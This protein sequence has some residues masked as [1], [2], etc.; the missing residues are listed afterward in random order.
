MIC[1]IWNIQSLFVEKII[2]EVN[3]IKGD[4][5]CLTETKKKWNCNTRPVYASLFRN[6]EFEKSK[7]KHCRT[8]TE[9]L[10]ELS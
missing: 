8:Y 9:E 5:F 6:R 10:K 3:N 7:D 1:R 4:N 2:E